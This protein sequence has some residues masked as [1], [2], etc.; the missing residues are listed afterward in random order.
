MT[1]SAREPAAQPPPFASTARTDT[2]RRASNEDRFLDRPDR[3]LW[4]VADG[5]GGH[6]LGEVASTLVIE[7][8]E[9]LGEFESGYAFLNAVVETLNHANRG[10]I[11]QGR[12]RGAGPAG[13][14][15]STVVAL[16]IHEGHYACVWAGDSRAYLQRDGR[17]RRL[18][19]D[20]SLVQEL[21]EGG[22][23]S[24]EQSRRHPGANIITRAVGVDDPLKLDVEHGAVEPGDVFLLCSDGL[25]GVVEDRELGAALKGGEPQAAADT[26]M[27]MALDGGA[28]DNVTLVVIRAG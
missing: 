11:D 4:A 15:G 7:G 25:T 20:H 8:L 26:L 17:L 13:P 28:R 5:M 3:G 27:R 10:L 6:R 2:G 18:T 9:A 21:V 19:R 24:P 16:L 1:R 22:S 23:L 12:D 14:I